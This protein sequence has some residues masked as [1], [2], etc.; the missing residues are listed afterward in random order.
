MT[1]FAEQGDPLVPNR[2]V[3][4]TQNA[5]QRSRFIASFSE[6]FGAITSVD[7]IPATGFELFAYTLPVGSNAEMVHAA[8]DAMMLEGTIVVGEITK[9][10]AEKGEQ[11][12]CGS[13]VCPSTISHS[14]NSIR[15][16]SSD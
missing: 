8:L 9:A 1:T 11:V 7:S 5:K 6:Q 16:H 12:R 4:K 10:R 13:R 3:I 14:K 2:M 15:D